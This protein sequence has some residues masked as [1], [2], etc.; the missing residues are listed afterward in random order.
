MGSEGNLVW[1]LNLCGTIRITGETREPPRLEA[2]Q[3]EG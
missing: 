3:G 2:N 1:F